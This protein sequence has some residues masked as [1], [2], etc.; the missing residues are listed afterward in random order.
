M[1]ILRSRGKYRANCGLGQGSRV[2]IGCSLMAEL[3]SA[4]FLIKTSSRTCL[5]ILAYP[6]KPVSSG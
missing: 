5:R 6:E 4:R 2:F 3:V 1:E